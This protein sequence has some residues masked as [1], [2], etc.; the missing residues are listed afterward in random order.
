MVAQRRA[1]GLD[2]VV[3]HRLDG[4]STK[5]SARRFGRPKRSAMVDRP[6]LRRQPR[7]EQRPRRLDVAQARHHALVAER[8]L[9]EG[10]LAGAGF[11][12]AC[13]IELI[14]SGSG[15]SEASCGSSCQLGARHQLSSR[16]GA[17]VEGDGG[18]VRHV[19]HHVVVR[20][21]LVFS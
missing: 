8:G 13:G 9:H 15:P 10:L 17:V 6:P 21:V 2:G 4:R 20:G 14:A 18:A 5:A 3:Q 19:K 7:A 12:P 16:S 1:A 11:R